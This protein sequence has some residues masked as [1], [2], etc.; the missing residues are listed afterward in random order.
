MSSFQN[1]IWKQPCCTIAIAYYCKIHIAQPV[2][3]KR[4]S[5]KLYKIMKTRTKQK[6]KMN[7]WRNF[8]FLFFLHN[9]KICLEKMMMML[10]QIVE[11]GLI[12]V[13]DQ[14]N[15]YN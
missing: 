6:N 3:M 8:C 10:I 1:L 15:M 2:C 11:N 12:E 13:T 5:C 9:N 7:N 4:N 14:N